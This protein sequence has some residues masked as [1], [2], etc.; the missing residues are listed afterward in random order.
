MKFWQDVW[1]RERPLHMCFKELFRISQDKDACVAELIQF[2]NGWDLHWDFNFI[3]GVQDW[4]L[5]HC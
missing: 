2:T 3:G 5:D 4:E 1:C